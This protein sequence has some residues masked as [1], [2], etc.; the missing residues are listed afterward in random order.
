VAALRARTREATGIK[1]V[2]RTAYPDAEVR[3]IVRQ[4]LRDA[5][6]SDVCVTV[7]QTKDS[8]AGGYWRAYWYP[9]DGEDRPQILV[10]LPKPGVTIADYAPYER[11][12][13]QGRAFPLADWREALVAIT[14]HE[15]EHH[16]QRFVL[17]ERKG[18]KKRRVDVELRCDLAAFR[19]WRRWRD[20]HPQPA[21]GE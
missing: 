2:N 5:E 13:E 10:R 16:R 21:E 19:A 6:V 12:R 8:H 20:S 3:R 15:A 17:G 9:E 7:R 11:V 14:A 4:Q 18:Y 1:V